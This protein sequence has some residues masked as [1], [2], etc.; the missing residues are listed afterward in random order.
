MFIYSNDLFKNTDSVRSDCK[1]VIESIIQPFVHNLFIIKNTTSLP[2][3]GIACY[4]ATLP[5]LPSKYMLDILRRLFTF[6]FLFSQCLYERFSEKCIQAIH[7]KTKHHSC[8]PVPIPTLVVL[9]TWECIHVTRNKC[10][11]M[12]QDWKTLMLSVLN[13]HYIHAISNTASELYLRVSIP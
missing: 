6:F 3:F 1:C 8:R 10:A 11:G 13:I 12:S 5:I 4:H 9:A 2:E 7:S